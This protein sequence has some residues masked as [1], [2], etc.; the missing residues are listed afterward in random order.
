MT[1]T[2]RLRLEFADRQGSGCLLITGWPDTEF[3]ELCGLTPGEL[4][5]RVVILPS[6]V[7]ATAGDDY[8]AFPTIA[9]SFVLEPESVCFMPRFPFR[10][11][12]SYA[13]VVDS[14]ASQDG[15]QVLTI[16]RPTVAATPTTE[17]VAIYPTAAEIPVNLLKVY[18]HFSTPMSE[19]W[20]AQAITV[21]RQDNGELLE[22]VFLPT[23]PELWDP[24]RRRL[25][26]LLDPGRIKRGLAPNLEAGYP[27]VEG[28]PVK[29]MVAPDFRD[30]GGRPLV[31]GAERCYRVGPPRRERIALHNWKLIPP[32]AGSAQPL[33]VEFDHPLDQ[34]LLQHC[35]T[36]KTTDGT[37]VSG[38]GEIGPEERSWRFSPENPWD[39]GPCRLTIAP[40]LE[41]LAGNSPL[42]VFDRDITIEDDA[43]TN[44][45]ALQVEF[46]CAPAS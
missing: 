21:C 29:V 42:R 15:P 7:L 43:P 16:Q 34:A 36:V 6:D 26:M 2:R 31:A 9:G 8:R 33:T 20:A 1:Q 32:V 3:A 14:G 45:D 13:V 28:V 30:A 17:V 40:H 4:A 22:G 37:P 12:M 38:Q 24:S 41:D 35:L 23:P 19:G 10:D 11:G 46:N 39:T 27:L 25:T 44:K 5:R 18:V